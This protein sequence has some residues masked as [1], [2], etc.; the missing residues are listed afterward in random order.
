M[1]IAID[2]VTVEKSAIFI[3][4]LSSTMIS[5][6]LKQSLIFLSICEC[7][8]PLPVIFPV[9]KLPHIYITIRKLE[10]S[11]PVLGS[12]LKLSLIFLTI[13][14]NDFSFAMRSSIHKVSSICVSR[15]LYNFTFE[16]E[17]V[18]FDIFKLQ[19]FSFTSVHV[20]IVKNS[21]FSLCFFWHSKIDHIIVQ[22]L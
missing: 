19:I 6:I 17:D 13:I 5:S 15:F 21:P 11:F 1:F 2:I 7:K 10:L 20:L 4:I 12:H 3:S 16:S 9:Q 18:C 22:K 8:F 14:K